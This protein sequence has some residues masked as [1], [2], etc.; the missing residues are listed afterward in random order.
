MNSKRPRQ[1][2]PMKICM[3]AYIKEKRPHRNVAMKSIIVKNIITNSPLFIL[4]SP[5]KTN[6][7][8]IL[9]LMLLDLNKL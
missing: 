1:V 3:K 4:F 5:F 6:Q 8:R 7:T 9:K 2:L